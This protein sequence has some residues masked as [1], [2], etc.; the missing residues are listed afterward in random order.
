MSSFAKEF[1]ISLLQR[2]KMSVKILDQNNFSKLLYVLELAC[3]SLMRWYFLMLKS[4]FSFW[5]ITTKINVCI[6]SFFFFR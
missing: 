1:F 4:I 3:G 6:K 5:F 2:R